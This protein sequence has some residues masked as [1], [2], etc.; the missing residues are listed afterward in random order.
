MSTASKVAS[1]VYNVDGQHFTLS[2]CPQQPLEIAGLRMTTLEAQRSLAYPD[3]VKAVLGKTGLER[4][5][6]RL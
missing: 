5:R 2:H 6:E 3:Y 4:A 1:V